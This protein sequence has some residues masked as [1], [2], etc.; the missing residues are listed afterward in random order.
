MHFQL[1]YLEDFL[2]LKALLDSVFLGSGRVGG[3]Y[4][5]PEAMVYPGVAVLN[6][7]VVPV[8]V[9]NRKCL[10]DREQRYTSAP[11]AGTHVSVTHQHPRRAHVS[12]LHVSIHGGHTCV[13]TWGRMAGC[14]LSCLFNCLLRIVLKNLEIEKVF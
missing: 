3:E 1:Q 12:A 2:N 7:G 10:R 14:P 8:P 11:T 5:E 13:R 6:S 4:T 9:L